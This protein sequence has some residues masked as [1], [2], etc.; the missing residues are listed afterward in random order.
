M[1][2]SLYLTGVDYWDSQSSLFYHAAHLADVTQGSMNTQM[3]SGTVCLC[4]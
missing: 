1:C 4:I 3:V 2:V